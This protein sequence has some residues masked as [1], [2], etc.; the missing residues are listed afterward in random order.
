MRRILVPV[1]LVFAATAFAADPLPR[2]KPE[3]VG[4]SSVRLARIGAA[5]KSDVDKGR[6]PGAVVA[7]ARRGKLVYFE[8]AGFL[9]KDAGVPMPKD[10]IFSIASMTKPMTSVAPRLHEDLS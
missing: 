9:D 1:I 8:A 3:A 5:L 7:I 4:M 6:L 2:A 10:A